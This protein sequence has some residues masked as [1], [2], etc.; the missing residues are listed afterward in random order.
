[1]KSIKTN[2]PVTV[3]IFVF[4][5]LAILIIAVFTLG[6]QKKTFVKAFA[7]NAVFN[8][9]AGLQEGNNVWFSGVKIGMVKKVSFY[10][11]FQVLVT[12][13][14]EKNAASHIHKDAKAKIGSDGLIGNKIVIIYGGGAAT[15]PVTKG[16]FLK[17]EKALST[18]DMLVTLQAN[19]KNLLVITNSFKSI[20]SKIDSG[21]GTIGTLLND[22]ALSNK[23]KVTVNNLQATTANFET[24]SLNSKKAVSDIQAFTSKLSAPG[25]LTNEIVTDTTVFNNLKNT[26]IKLRESANTASQFLD[27]LKITGESLNRK[28]N[29]AGIILNDRDVAASLKNTIKN[30]EISSQ[31]LSENL[32][33]LQHNFLLK[34]YFKKQARNKPQ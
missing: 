9:V 17:V 21:G 33:A 31:K 32:E 27:N 34:G 3:G 15:A 2:R 26:V 12:M 13:N 28:D 22:V 10:G 6:N 29:T 8:D 16:D 4:L 25:S 11:N 14:L 23:L 18:E 20:A 19:N 24:A 5:G 1:M 30:L 7:V